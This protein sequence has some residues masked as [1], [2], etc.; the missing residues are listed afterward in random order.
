MAIKEEDLVTIT[1]ADFTGSDFVRVLDGDSSRKITL[2]SFAE[3]LDPLLVAEGFIKTVPSTDVA[4]RTVTAN[5]TLDADTDQV[6]L[7]DTTSGNIVVTLPAANLMGTGTTGT[8]YTVK[9]KTNDINKVTVVTT[10]G[11]TIDGSSFVDI[12]GPVMGSVTFVSD[13]FNIYTV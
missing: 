11:A 1:S 2:G 12:I 8:R 4:I 9:K 13:S 7:A 6:I 5:T 10:G 3:S